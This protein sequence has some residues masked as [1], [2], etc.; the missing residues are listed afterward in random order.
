MTV[1][2]TAR[3][4]NDLNESYPRAKDLISE[5]DDHIR[6]LKAV[7]KNTMPGFDSSVTMTSDKLNKIDETLEYGED[8]VITIT[9]SLEMKAG[10]TLDAGGN[11]ITNL[12]DPVDPSDAVPLSYLRG[13]GTWPIGSIFMTVDSRNPAVIL[14]FGTWEEFAAGRVIIGTGKAT[15][16]AS[17]TRTFKNEEKGGLFEVKL[18]TDNLPEHVHLLS[19][20][21]SKTTPMGEHRHNFCTDDNRTGEEA[22]DGIEYVKRYGGGGADGGNTMC[23]YRTSQEPDHVHGVVG[24]TDVNKTSKTG[25][26]NIQPWIGVNIWK[27]V[28]DPT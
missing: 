23:M 9:S 12:G 25:F 8:G 13:A 18:T 21:K 10:K 11:V 3:F 17:V 5:G 6:M 24:E 26:D 14:G 20:D 27:R 2:N 15:D 19:A 22:A 4:I 7:L 16:S 1:E 28:A